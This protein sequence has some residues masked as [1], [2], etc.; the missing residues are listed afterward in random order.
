MVENADLICNLV[1]DYYET[2]I[3][4]GACRYGENLPAI[5]RIGGSF[6]MAPRTVRAALSR[7]EKNGYIEVSPRKTAKVIYQA[8]ADQIKE[9]A[10][11]YF[12][13]RCSGIIDFCQAGKL[14]I[15]PVWE[16]AQKSY[17]KESWDRLKEN[18]AK[19]KNVDLSIS[20]RMHIQVFSDLGNKLILNFYWELLR[21]IRFPYLANHGMHEERDRELLADGREQ[22]LEFMNAAFEGDFAACI[23]QLL[24]FCA[25]MDGEYGRTEKVP[26]YWNIYWQRPQ[27]CYTMASR[28]I[29]E[30]I[31]GTYP[32][33]GTLPS[34]PVMS[35]QLN[36]SYRTLR[37]TLCIL[38]SL[39]IIRLHQGKVSD[40]CEDIEQ[41]DFQRPEVKEGF[42]LYRESLQFM[43]LTVR[44]VFLYTLEHVEKEDLEKLRHGFIQLL[45]ENQSERC[46][47]L[48]LEF[49]VERCPSAAVR[50]CYTRLAEFL[51]WGYPFAL[52][53][54][55]KQHLH[56]EYTQMVRKSAELLENDDWEGY[57]DSWKALMEYEQKRAEKILA[58]YQEQG[59]MV[60]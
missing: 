20:T 28:I 18:M 6:Q 19:L 59:R 11:L 47:K 30:I 51:V 42:R 26:F 35:K 14:L 21:Y 7:L 1:Y 24:A 60:L 23:S 41:I 27:L 13:P 37:R 38:D 52:Y 5:P 22:E 15:E 54:I 8:S 29:T 46:F 39:S 32:V 53:R 10:A 34:M 45:N 36:V 40:V 49:I 55:R 2:R 31:K 9:N 56:E 3:L 25:E 33:G 57:A 17:D 58:D 16:Y 12:V 48:A 43:A 4:L 44:P 50:E